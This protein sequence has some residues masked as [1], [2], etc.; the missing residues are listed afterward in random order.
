[1]Q[2]MFGEN[3]KALLTNANQN[4]KENNLTQPTW[5]NT[6]L[7]YGSVFTQAANK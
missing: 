7:N 4:K 2:S 1:M 6:Q 5:T 3:L